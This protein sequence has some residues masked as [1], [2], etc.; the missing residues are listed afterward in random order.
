[1]SLLLHTTPRI[2]DDDDDD[3]DKDLHRKH[4]VYGMPT[5]LHMT[6]IR[7]TDVL[8]SD[9]DDDEQFLNGSL[10]G[11][12]LDS[13]RN[14]GSMSSNGS[15]S[16]SDRSGSSSSSSADEEKGSNVYCTTLVEGEGEDRDSPSTLSSDGISRSPKPEHLGMHSQSNSGQ[17]RYVHS[18]SRSNS[19]RNATGAVDNWGWFDDESTEGSRVNRKQR[20]LD[21]ST[22]EILPLND[23]NKEKAN[24]KV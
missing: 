3:D 10:N 16:S 9:D 23:M 20:L 15:V 5:Y 14:T 12:S 6:D 2:D 17:M 24:G 1:M 18:H 8:I 4:I 22:M 19:I 13:S 11:M 7:D 21:F